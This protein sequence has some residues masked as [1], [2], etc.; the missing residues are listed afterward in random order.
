[1]AEDNND[2]LRAKLQRIDDFKHVFQS[3]AGQ[4]V[5]RDLEDFAG[6]L[7]DGFD[8]DP[9]VTAYN[10]GRRSVGVYILRMLEMSR[11]DLQEMVRKQVAEG[12]VSN[13]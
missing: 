8:P 4:R 13:G 9:N 5:L 2:A 6:L 1:M 12:T 7:S 10:A 11:D 3:D